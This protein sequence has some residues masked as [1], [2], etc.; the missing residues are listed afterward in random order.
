MEIDGFRIDYRQKDGTLT[1]TFFSIPVASSGLFASTLELEQYAERYA[2][3]TF[4]LAYPG[5]TIVSLVR[6][7]LEKYTSMV[8]CA[9]RK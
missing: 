6:M 3:Y 4:S 1:N 5:C 9:R 2:R 7:S 8:D